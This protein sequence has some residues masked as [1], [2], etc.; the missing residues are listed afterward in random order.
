[1]LERRVD[2]SKGRLQRAAGFSSKF[3]L[4]TGI[5]PSRFNLRRMNAGKCKNSI[6]EQTQ[7]KWIS[8]NAKRLWNKLRCF[9]LLFGE[10]LG[11]HD[12]VQN[13]IH[14][15]NI[16]IPQGFSYRATFR[17]DKQIICTT[18]HVRI[19]VHFM[20][21]ILNYE[22]DDDPGY[23]LA[24][25]ESKKNKVDQEDDDFEDHFMHGA[26]KN[27]MIATLDRKNN[28]TLW[29]LTTLERKLH[30]KIPFNITNII[31]IT[32]NFMY[33][34]IVN[35][36]SL[37][38]FTPK[39]DFT[40][41]KTLPHNVQILKYNEP[42]HEIFAA[43]IHQITVWS[44]SA[45]HFHGAVQIQ[46]KLKLSMSTGL[47][48][49]WLS[50]IYIQERTNQIYATIDTGFMAFDLSTGKR[51]EYIQGITRRKISF[52]AHHDAYQYMLLGCID[53]SIKVVN[54]ARAT[55]HEFVNHTKTVISI[56]CSK[57]GPLIVTSG[58]DDHIRYFFLMIECSTL[59]HLRKYLNFG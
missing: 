39:L 7:R 6:V 25:L 57:F 52:L 30:Q 12:E 21:G 3:H 49:L 38:F 14:P 19:P 31:F 32:K 13:N 18:Y 47:S 41:R 24:E 48:D 16:S 54:F 50:S 1:M 58:L 4:I 51:I 17:H 9:V 59:K 15:Y 28:F 29:D 5:D 44:L 53:G 33:A 2:F 56:S 11:E 23:T 34:G 22:N 35:G 10:E 43:G 36:N 55:V 46:A 42:T 45:V 26:V 37:G 8:A 40:S 27:Y 20:D